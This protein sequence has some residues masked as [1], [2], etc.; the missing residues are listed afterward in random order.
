MILYRINPIG[1]DEDR[2]ELHEGELEPTFGFYGPNT[3][4]AAVGLGIKD[5]DVSH[6]NFTLE[7]TWSELRALG[8]YILS[9][10]GDPAAEPSAQ[11]LTKEPS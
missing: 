3:Q 6:L 11:V 10:A 1:S 5:D 4:D 7:G 2:T 8:H 9:I